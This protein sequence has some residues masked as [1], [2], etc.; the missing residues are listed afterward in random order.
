MHLDKGCY[1]SQETVAA[2]T[3]WGKPRECWCCCTSTDPTPGPAPGD[4]LVAGG[5]TIGGGW[6]LSSTMWTSADALACSNEV[7][8]R[9]LSCSGGEQQVKADIPIRC[10]R[11]T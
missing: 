4:P 1:R 3:T 7:F 10:H 9:T 11:R 5:R 8:P 2:S 6:A